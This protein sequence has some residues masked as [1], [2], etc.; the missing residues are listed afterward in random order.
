MLLIMQFRNKRKTKSNIELSIFLFFFHISF[1]FVF[2][3][4]K[5]E[6]SLSPWWYRCSV[7]DFLDQTMKLRNWCG[8][9]EGI[10]SYKLQNRLFI[11]LSCHLASHV[12]R[13]KGCSW[14]MIW[15]SFWLNLRQCKLLWNTVGIVHCKRKNTFFA[16][17]NWDQEFWKDL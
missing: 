17:C 16:I 5:D 8:L 9:R 3:F 11:I 15:H 13:E 7:S 14:C 12:R 4:Y 2:L 10:C 6:L 1:K